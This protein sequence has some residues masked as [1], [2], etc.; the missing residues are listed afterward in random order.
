MSHATSDLEFFMCDLCRVYVHR[1][2]Y[3]NHR[4]ECKGLDS[5]ELKKGEVNALS[6]AIGRSCRA[7]YLNGGVVPL[8][9][10]EKIG[11]SK[12][13]HKIADE[14]VREKDEILK[15]RMVDSKDLLALLD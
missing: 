9:R 6:E 3:C 1:D 15:Q 2:I 13:R 7:T 12:R 4:R 10:V 8:Q 11:E 5:K 14:Y